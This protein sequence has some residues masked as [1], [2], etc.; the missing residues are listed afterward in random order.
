[1]PS[2]KMHY[3]N[4]FPDV[5]LTLYPVLPGYFVFFFLGGGA[6]TTPIR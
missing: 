4:F 3:F 1:M 5:G 6:I 2:V